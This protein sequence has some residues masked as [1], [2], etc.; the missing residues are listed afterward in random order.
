MTDSV[1]QYIVSNYNYK[2]TFRPRDYEIWCNNMSCHGQYGLTWVTACRLYARRD[3][4]YDLW[5]LGQAA[6]GVIGVGV[7]N[8]TTN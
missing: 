5:T 2:D 8:V 3:F 4:T 7:C 6:R 1:R